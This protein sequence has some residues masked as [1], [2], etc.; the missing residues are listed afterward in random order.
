MIEVSS[1]A[2]GGH[3]A[4][5]DTR[6]GRDD[7]GARLGEGPVLDIVC[8]HRTEPPARILERVFA[9]LQAHIGDV[10]RRDDLTLVLVRS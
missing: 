10:V 8:R 7:I 6:F 9:A 5:G 3:D 4:R 1:D 2:L